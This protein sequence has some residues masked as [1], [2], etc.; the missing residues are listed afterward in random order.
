M[1]NLCNLCGGFEAQNLMEGEVYGRKG[2]TGLVYRP[3]K[4]PIWAPAPPLCAC[5]ALHGSIL[6]LKLLNI[7]LNADPD[8]DPVSQNL[9]AWNTVII[10]I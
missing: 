5:A 2:I 6:P 1:G 9:Q 3:S 8:P 4:A 10:F 7:D